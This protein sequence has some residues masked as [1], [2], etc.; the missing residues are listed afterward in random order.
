[1]LRFVAETLQDPLFQRTLRM[2]WAWLLRIR[3]DLWRMRRTSVCRIRDDL[4][5]MRRIRVC[6]I[7]DDLQRMK[8]TR[9]VGSGMTFGG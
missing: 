7:R 2:G 9:V 3:D 6:R 4:R 1:M 5:R 8:R